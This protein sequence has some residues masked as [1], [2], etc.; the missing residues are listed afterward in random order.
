MRLIEIARRPPA[1]LRIAF[2]GL[3]VAFVL[4]SIAHVTHRHEALPGNTAHI[5]ACGYCLNFGGLADASA[6]PVLLLASAPNDE[7]VIA[8]APLLRSFRN[9]SA[10]QP[11]AP[12]VS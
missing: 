11:R 9:P 1:W 8:A 3:V 2:A 10:A 7:I 6:Q 5:V 12:P 4:N